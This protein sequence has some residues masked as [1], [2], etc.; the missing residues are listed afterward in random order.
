MKIEQGCGSEVFRVFGQAVLCVRM[1]KGNWLLTPVNITCTWYLLTFSLC[2]PRLGWPVSPPILLKLLFFRLCPRL[3]S[4]YIPPGPF[5]PLLQLKFHLHMLTAFKFLSSPPDWNSLPADGGG[6]IIGDTCQAEQ[7][8]LPYKPVAAPLC[9]FSKGQHYFT[10]VCKLQTRESSLTFHSL[11]YHFQISH[12]RLLIIPPKF[13]KSTSFF[14]PPS[15]SYARTSNL[16]Y[17]SLLNG[18]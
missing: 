8:S 18:F 11:T 7:T 12:Q 10:Q 17:H 13:L 5:N 6:C 14:P 1:T 9:P 16:Y 3:A 15:S 2:D 4:F